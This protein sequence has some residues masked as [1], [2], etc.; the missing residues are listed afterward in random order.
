MKHISNQ[1]LILFLAGICLML[2]QFFMI[3][4]ISAILRG[5]EIVILLVTIAYFSGYSVG[6][7][8]SGS[9]S[10]TG[11]RLLAVVFWMLHITLPFSLRYFAAL[12]HEKSAGWSFAF[13]IFFAMF[14]LSSFYSLL[15]PWFTDKA[16]T[17]DS[18]ARLY[19]AE[20]AG[21]VTGAVAALTLGAYPMAQ[22]LLYQAS[23]AG[24]VFLLWPK[25]AVGAMVA[26][27]FGIYL[28]A[29]QNMERGS[30]VAHYVK[31]LHFQQADPLLS[32]NSP[33]Q[34][35][36]FVK[37]GMTGK[38]YIFL[39]GN[40]NFGSTSLE[41]FN[42]FLSRMPAQ[43]LHPENTLVIGA[44]SLQSVRNVAPHSGHVQVVEIDAAVANGSRRFLADVN[45]LETISNWS[46]TIQDAKNYLGSTDKKFDLIVV[47]VPAPLSIQLG[48]LHSVEFYALA[49]G[50]L[51][52]K[53]VLSI[54]LSGGFSQT[55]TTP[56]TVAAAALAVFEEA[57][58]VNPDIPGRSFIMASRSLSFGK[59]DIQRAGLNMGYKQI[60]VF[61]KAEALRI[62]GDTAPMSL[63]D[64]SYPV[65]R[66]LRLVVKRHITGEMP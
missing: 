10:Q 38:T 20:L 22:P 40:M 14:L 6:Y 56:K 27:G 48:L 52:E 57:L 28:L 1:L 26:I 44:G 46:L 11:L 5:T 23:L 15:L 58:L 62:V 34:K 13:V 42:T 7:A 65:L 36:D 50:R 8:L 16:G 43:L 17:G 59:E 47:D 37:S 54:S 32:V 33:Y 12:L 29:F 30:L 35:V 19:G 2:L 25:K 63:D 55:A 64:M 41:H 4:E 18:L 24:L 31:S 61:D 53:G 39:D 9:F 49:R 3:R 51:T 45:R 21:A 60:A 66:S